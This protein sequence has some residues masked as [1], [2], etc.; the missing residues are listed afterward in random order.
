MQVAGLGRVP[1]L[2]VCPARNCAVGVVESV[3]LFPYGF[4]CVSGF[5]VCTGAC[6]W[7]VH[8]W[9]AVSLG[10]D[11]AFPAAVSLPV[12][13]SASW[14]CPG[15]ESEQEPLMCPQAH[16]ASAQPHPPLNLQSEDLPPQV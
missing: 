16:P 1:A 8:V 4:A 3:C 11:T 9:S 5:A 6:V 2:C 15:E 12:P 14:P 13:L 7:C 10:P